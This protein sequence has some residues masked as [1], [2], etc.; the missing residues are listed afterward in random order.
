M[1]NDRPI[2]R[3]LPL[4]SGVIGSSGDRKNQYVAC[5]PAHQDAKQSLAVAET[6]DGKVV[7]K[8]YAGCGFNEI[9]AALNLK[10]AD[11]F[12]GGTER[13]SSGVT[14]SGLAF[15]K[16]LP[17][18]WLKSFCGLS[19]TGGPG[20]RHVLIPYR[21]RDGSHLFDRLRTAAKAK[22][23]SRWV[24]GTN[25]TAYGLW[26]LDQWKEAGR[27]IVVE[28]ESDC[29]AGWLNGYP[30]LGV[31][32]ASAGK[33]LD[34]DMFAGFREVFVWQ[35]TDKAGAEFVADVV[36]RLAGIAGLTVKVISRDGI[37]DPCELHQRYADGFREEFEA[38]LAA[39]KAY[40]PAT[41][42]AP[43]SRKTIILPPER[44]DGDEM[45]QFPLTEYGNA[46]RLAWQHGRDIRYVWHGDTSGEWFSW[47]GRRWAR[48][49][50][51][52]VSQCGM[53]TV[54]KIYA[55]AE[56]EKDAIK[57]QAIA[58]H[59]VKSE[60]WSSS[61][62]ML[63][64]AATLQNLASHI[65]AFDAQPFRLNVMNGTV[66]L[67][68]GKLADHR[69]EDFSTHIAP[70]TFDADA[71]CPNWERFLN[72]VF[73]TSPEDPAAAPDHE[74]IAFI[75]RLLGYCLTGDVSEHILPIFWGGG[76]NGKSTLLNV[77]AGILGDGYAAKAPQG[78]LMKKHGDQHPTE[79][80]V[81][82]GARFVYASETARSGRLSEELVKDLTSG[83]KITARRM[84]MDFFSFSPSHKLIM[85]TNHQPRIGDA[86]DGIWR[87]VRMVPFRAR[88]WNPDSEIGPEHLKQNKQLGDALTSERS[89]I[90]NWL[91]E[92]V[93]DWR[94]NGM[95]IPES[96]TAETESYRHDEDTFG[97]FMSEA[98]SKTNEACMKV[99]LSD[100]C[101]NY[102]DWCDT[103]NTQ[104]MSNRSVSSELR[105][106][107][108]I[109]KNG[110]G[111]K[112]TVFS[113]RMKNANDISQ[114]TGKLSDYDD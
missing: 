76:A 84:R 95:A 103:Q 114:T 54:R 56:K 105:R 88:F 92:G 77:M 80:T 69:R 70:V 46:E 24:T 89:G 90:L 51:P 30:F 96:V 108:F 109:V 87:R 27:L 94:K 83:E 26:L 10:P 21:G 62:A 72:V 111:N 28:G 9:A 52:I 20:N 43:A 16:R 78:M 19:D 91:I 14:V 99:L 82:Q 113:I 58:N 36:E 79:L 104:P 4:L 33:V 102:R 32:G 34:A 74:L 107:G 86:D 22:D 31:P 55:E 100:F 11:F 63:K 41:R 110:S 6:S 71:K 18:E 65:E 45:P 3:I 106:R 57:R 40:D 64:H 68:T 15:D 61:N 53:R 67:L 7:V 42:P 1:N 47:D 2:E 5:C 44:T 39:A 60:S 37:K 12:P 23:G 73:S 81:L 35:E 59:A 49:S 112:V 48:N 17:T 97:Q 29:W 8:C 50:R 75:R 66:D 93:L 98:I 85:C 38:I 13:R 25:P 101:K